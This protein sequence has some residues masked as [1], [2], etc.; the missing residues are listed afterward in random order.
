MNSG[1]SSRFS[2]PKELLSASRIERKGPRLQPGGLRAGA[3]E[4][5]PAV[6]HVHLSRLPAVN[7]LRRLRPAPWTSQCEGIVVETE[8]LKN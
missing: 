4:D 7:P 8:E 3:A 1:L 5:V 6:R 2:A